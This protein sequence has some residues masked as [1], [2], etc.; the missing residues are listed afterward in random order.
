MRQGEFAYDIVIPTIGRPSLATLLRSLASAAGPL[1]ER[2]LIVDDRRD[3]SAPL[4]IGSDFGELGSRIAIVRGAAAGPAAARNRGLAR[5]KAPWIAFL[6]DDVVVDANWRRDLALDCAACDDACAGSQGRVSVPLPT[7]REP[8]DWERNV[9]GLEAARW[10]TADCAYRRAALVAVRGF[11]ERFPRAYREDAELG[12]RLIARGHTIALGRRRVAHPVRPADA[13][14]SVR[15]QAGNADDALMAALHGSDWYER[16]GAAR[17]SFRQ[18]AA[19]VAFAVA[20]A[21][22]T[23]AWTAATAR[24]AWKRIAPGPRDAAEIRAMLLTSAAIPF[25]AVYHRLRGAFGLRARLRRT[26]PLPAAVLFDR[27][28]TLVVD[29]PELREP[30][31]LR[32][33]RGARAAL[34]RLR[35][36][37][38][39]VG[40]VTNQ[41]RV[42]EGTLPATTLAALHARLEELAGPFATIGACPHRASDGCACRKPEPGLIT[43][44][45]EVLGIETSDCIVVGDIGSDVE[46]AK[47]AG[48]RAIIVP[49]PVTRRA[50]I[51]AAPVRARDLA[52]AVDLIL[53]GAA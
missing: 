30:Q 21:G 23:A 13:W 39:E 15:L 4:V 36:A 3:H 51:A 8:T 48:A 24:F 38:I 50:E 26:H 41:P 53:G 9:R 52:R 25:A 28:G 44:A 6:D 34:E 49:T 20:A 27:D 11:D 31:R 46:A 29:D 32:L 19:T 2:L 14:I 33:V 5:A 17:G 42:G 45:A 1:P 12:L 18:H 35:A 16:A 10:I 40:V 37:G 47:A 22:F 7:Y 43:A